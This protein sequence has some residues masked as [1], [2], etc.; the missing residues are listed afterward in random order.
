MGFVV[1]PGRT[2]CP[3]EV[4]GWRAAGE[5]TLHD[6][7][8]VRAGLAR[9]GAP[10]PDGCGDLELLVRSFLRLGGDGLRAANGMFTVALSRNDELVLVRDHV[11]AR[12]AY[13]ALTPRGW[14][15]GSSLRLLRDHVVPA[16]F[17]WRVDLPA[18]TTFLTFAYLPGSE[19][20]VE[21]VAE[22]LPGR[23]TRLGPG[24]TVASESFWEPRER[25]DA[26]MDAPVR[27]REA[28]ERATAARLPTGRP[29][30][31]TLSG[32]IDSS[33]V[34]ALAAKLHTHPVHTYSISFGDELP[35][36]L[37]YSGL[38][39]AHCGTAHRVLRVDGARVAGRLAETV[40]LLDNPV[41][42][43]LTVP[44]LVLA[45]AMA[46]DGMAVA[47]NGEGGDPVFGGPKNV[48]MLMFE[49]H[50]DDPSPE[51]RAEAYLRSYRKCGEDL[52]RLLT[53]AVHAALAGAPSPSRHV[54]PYLDGPMTAQLNRLLHTNLRTKGAHHILPKVGRLTAAHGIEARAPLFDA[55]VVDLA[56]AVPPRLKLV[57]GQEKWVLKQA[58]ADLLPDTIV[59]RPKSGMRVPVQQWLRGPLRDLAHDA[60]LSRSSA[61]RG[62]LRCEVVAGWLA[63]RGSVHARHGAK[64]WLVLTLE[65]WLR[66]HVD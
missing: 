6:E 2:D 58:V 31:V 54:R 11:G 57:D 18:V 12:T 8:A 59:H 52:P 53:P 7:P 1:G 24:G 35:N 14:A 51:A 23:I 64:L 19:T 37:A 17:G 63:G 22:L 66:A 4:D 44:N 48:P 61:D 36:E 39:A 32:G 3:V 29:V 56:F 5:V 43:P 46:A 38:V 42:D 40:A 28:L 9:A 10:A 27:L 13:Y 65:L 25:I 20:L 30:A 33:L 45:E 26:S 60:L 21:G 47:L 16:G 41:G 34:T 62:V 50:R 55:A 15:A 49:L